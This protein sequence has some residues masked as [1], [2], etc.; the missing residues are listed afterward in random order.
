VVVVLV[1]LRLVLWLVLGGRL[2][3]GRRL[4]WGLE[5]RLQR[6]LVLVVRGLVLVVRGLLLGLLRLWLMRRR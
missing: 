3:L 5:W 1:L 4:M 2:V 6:R